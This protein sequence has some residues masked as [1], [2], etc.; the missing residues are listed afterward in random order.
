MKIPGLFPIMRDWQAF[1]RMHFIYAAHESGL[2]EALSTPASRDDLIQKLNV[3]RPEILEAL[4][5]RIVILTTLGLA[6]LWFC[7]MPQSLL[8]DKESLS[9]WEWVVE[10]IVR[11][12]ACL[13]V[14]I[15]AFVHWR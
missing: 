1:V 13:G 5:W 2:L 14:S 4:S 9:M 8:F 15:G 11:F 12:A 10:T 3:R 7:L 6:I